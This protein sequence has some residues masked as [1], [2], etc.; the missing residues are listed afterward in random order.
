M[1]GQ[2]GDLSEATVEE[3]G[4][5]L[6]AGEITSV[7]L[8]EH[9]LKRIDALDRH[10]PHLRSVLEL[11]PDAIDIARALDGERSGGT[12]RGPLH[13]I[14]VLLKDNL[15]TG[16]RML[17]TAGSL[18]LTGA[19]APD[20]AKLV[21]RLRAAGAVLLGKTNLSE[22][23]NF[24]STRSSSGWSGRGRQTK[25]PYVLDRTP[26]GSSSGSA[27]AVAAGMAPA[28]VGTET[29]GSI[30]SPAS[31]CGVVGFKPAVGTVSQDG[32]IPISHSQDAAGPMARTVRDAALLGGSMAETGS[33]ASWVAACRPGGL[34]DAR[35]GVLREPFTGSNPHTDR[36]FDEALT[37]MREEG[38]TLIDPVS[39]ESA[40]EMRTSGVERTVLLHEFKAGVDAYLATRP[41]LEVRSLEDLVAFNRRHAVEEM[42][43]FGQELFEQALACGPLTDPVYLE[44][45]AR[46][47]ELG[48]GRGIDLALAEHRL[49][50]LVAPTMNPPWVID[51]VAPGRGGHGGA[52]QPAAMAGY[53][54]VSV[55]AGY[56]VGELPVGISFFAGAGSEATLLRLAFGFEQAT[57]ARRRPRFLATLALD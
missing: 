41:G 6:G 55:P 16:D 45:A 40:E 51:L 7:E 50:A 29:D 9:C 19:P 13:G 25:N 17:T 1:K 56:A 42:P 49:Q 57:G 35:I 33:A 21:A 14:P 11:N 28:A 36:I 2:R 43:Y 30:V 37:A 52:S 54:I 46:S 8:I 23:A 26:V 34:R 47:R 24:R 22:W 53:P 44:A 10:G 38:A 5:W 48:R 15:D 39:L 20:D 18:A 27:A 4:G 32:I 12:V 31:A 3:L